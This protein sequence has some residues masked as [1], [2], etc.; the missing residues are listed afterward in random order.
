MNFHLKD[1]LLR[2]ACLIVDKLIQFVPLLMPILFLVWSTNNMND[3]YFTVKSI[4]GSVTPYG[5]KMKDVNCSPI[6]RMVIHKAYYGYFNNTGIF[7]GSAT[8]D[9]QCTAVTS[10]K[11]KFLCG[12]QRSCGLT[13]DSNLLL[14]HFCS[15]TRK[16]LYTEY[17]C[18]DDY[19]DPITSNALKFNV[20]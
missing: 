4:S 3:L 15:N 8:S 17:T 13:I 9:A 18:V 5:D 10:C 12:G 2:H 1:L 7:N 19:P 14:P 16:E 6:Q 20:I 11:I